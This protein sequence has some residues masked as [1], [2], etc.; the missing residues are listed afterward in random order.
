MTSIQL[1]VCKINIYLLS[2]PDNEHLN[3]PIDGV[4]SDVIFKFKLSIV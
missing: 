2:N 1:F 3:N 4:P